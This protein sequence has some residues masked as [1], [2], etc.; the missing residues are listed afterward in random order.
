MRFLFSS[1]PAWGHL[2]PL[3]PLA[4]AVAAAGHDVRVAGLE[5]FTAPVES[6]GLRSWDLGPADPARPEPDDPPADPMRRMVWAASRTWTRSAHDGASPLLA[7]CREW[8]P[9]VVVHEP[10]EYAGP[11]VAAVLGIPAVYFRNGAAFPPE[12]ARAAA[13]DLAGTHDR[14]G[15]AAGTPPPAGYLD[16]CPPS[17][18]D[19]SAP[20]ASIL[21]RPEQV[22]LGTAAGDPWLGLPTGRRVLVTMGTMDQGPQRRV[23]AEAVRAA[24]C[25][26]TTGQVDAV[27]VAL[28]GARPDELDGASEGGRPE[29]VPPAMRLAGWVP[30]QDAVRGASLVLGHGGSGISLVCARAGRVQVAVPH[31]GEQPNM[32]ARLE[33]A[34]AAVVVPLGQLDQG[35]L[36]TA[37]AR[38]MSDAAV[39]TRV[40]ALAAETEA[41]PAPAAAVPALERLVAS[42]LPERS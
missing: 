35:R 39:R 1:S 36:A 27:L 16:C 15:L 26:L 10:V 4:H 37:L 23:L 22:R 13:R 11:L 40:A 42:W 8:R 25:A 33:A 34:G 2:L 5:G 20:A 14:F 3:L 21:V 17:L 30:M 29:P 9:E 18:Q 32:A 38:A 12:V 31:A 6:L 41:M 28:G 7:A 24:T 19:P